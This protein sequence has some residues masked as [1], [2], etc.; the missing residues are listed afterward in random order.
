[1]T[2]VCTPWR[3]VCKPLLQLT[4]SSKSSIGKPTTRVVRGANSNMVAGTEATVPAA[5]PQLDMSFP[6]LYLYTL[7]MALDTL[8]EQSRAEQ[9]RK[10]W[11]V[12]VRVCRWYEKKRRRKNGERRVSGAERA[13][14]AGMDG[15]WAVFA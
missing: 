3:I 1:M 2:N 8:S 12:Y 6:C 11:A 7:S 15:E 9:S 13:G 4:K 5:H 14:I 10:E